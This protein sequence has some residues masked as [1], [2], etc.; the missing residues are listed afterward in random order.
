MALSSFKQDIIAQGFART[1]RYTDRAAS[2]ANPVLNGKTPIAV[3]KI[4]HPYWQ[5]Y[6]I[7]VPTLPTPG[8]WPRYWHLYARSAIIKAALPTF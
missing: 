4:R 3:D 5:P 2:A 7:I 6:V 8:V 1:S